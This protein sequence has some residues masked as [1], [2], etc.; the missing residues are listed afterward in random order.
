MFIKTFFLGVFVAESYVYQITYWDAKRLCKINETALATFK[1]LYAAWQADFQTFVKIVF[2]ISQRPKCYLCDVEGK[3][4][5]L[6]EYI[7]AQIND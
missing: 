7:N 6:H 5:L 4:S 3:T 2:P 1:R